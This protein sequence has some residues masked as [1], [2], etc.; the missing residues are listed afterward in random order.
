ML[1]KMKRAAEDSKAVPVVEDK[2]QLNIDNF[3]LVA[4]TPSSH[5]S[6]SRCTSSGAYNNNSSNNNSSS[7]GYESK[8]GFVIGTPGSSQM[9]ASEVLQVL[10]KGDDTR[11]LDALKSL[12]FIKLL[13][14]LFQLAPFT[15]LR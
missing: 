4:T 10:S 13:S 11:L 12:C 2:F 9:N 5:T 7:S 3:S 6:S 15:L 14:S 1:K 8:D